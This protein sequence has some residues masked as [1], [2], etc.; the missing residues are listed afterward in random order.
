VDTPLV[1]GKPLRAGPHVFDVRRAGPA[2]GPP[3][4]LLHGFPQGPSCWDAVAARLARDGADVLAPAQR[5]Y[6]PGARPADVARYALPELVEDALRFAEALRPDGSAVHVA[7]HDWGAVV[8]WALAARHPERVASLT[9]VSVP[10][11]AAY[12]EALRRSR[13]QQLRSS[14]VGLFR[15]PGVV[16]RLLTAGNARGLRTFLRRSG[17]PRAQAAAYAELLGHRTALA[18]ALGWYRANSLRA[19]VK[20]ADVTVPTTFV[21]GS[22]DPAVGRR[23]AEGAARHVRG[24]YRFVELAGGSHWL[25]ERAPD[26]VFAAVRARLTAAPPR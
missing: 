21:W 10:H 19:L 7:G 5:G 17:V 14:Y 4:L 6:S 2:G 9:A 8:G 16:E 1:A 15:L 22:A 3:V 24:D 23:A 13:V 20:V 11:P 18:A 12:A 25:P 26:E